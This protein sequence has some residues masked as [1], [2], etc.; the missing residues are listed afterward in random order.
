MVLVEQGK[1]IPM[2]IRMYI[3]PIKK[4]IA[5]IEWNENGVNALVC[6]SFFG[7]LPQRH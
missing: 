3:L 7:F 2:G 1:D 6:G 5:F 4:P